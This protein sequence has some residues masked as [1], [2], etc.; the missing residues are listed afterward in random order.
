M[1]NIAAAL[2]LSMTISAQLF[3]GTT[4]LTKEQYID[5]IPFDTR[6]IAIA[7]LQA[8]AM[9]TEFNMFEEAYVDDI[10]FDTQFISA[11]HQAA[12]AM[13]QAFEMKH[14][15][16]VNDIPF[17]TWKVAFKTRLKEVILSSLT[18]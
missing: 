1:K 13:E 14:E 17:N 8:E 12:E 4:G 3:A 7:H 2:I 16:Y 15:A 5:D 6:A 11:Y 10:P 9:T 18:I